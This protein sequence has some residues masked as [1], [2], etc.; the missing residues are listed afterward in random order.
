M[1]INGSSRSNGKFFA[2]HLLRADHNERVEVVEIR[3][4]MAET[5]PAAFREMEAVAS[6]TNCKNYFY[7]ANLNT[8]ADEQLTREQWAEAVDILEKELGLTGQPRFV[9]EHTKE[10]RT[11]QHVVWSRI[12]TDNW[13]AISDSLTYQKHEQAARQ[14]EQRFGHQE[15]P[16]VLVKD[17]DKERPQRRPKDWET[18]RAQES[19]LDPKVITAEITALW[20]AADSASAFAAALAERG[21]ILARGDRRDFCIIDPAGNDHS[22]ARRVSGVKAAGIRER[23]ADLD[24]DALPSVEEGRALARQ[25]HDSTGDTRK[26]DPRP[27]DPFERALQR[28]VREARAQRAS[29]PKPR[30]AQQEPGTARPDRMA[31]FESALLGAVIRASLHQAQAKPD[32]AFRLFMAFWDNMHEYIAGLGEWVHDQFDHLFPQDDP[33]QKNTRPA[34]EPDR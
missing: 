25:R 1:I 9:V 24:R 19:K 34:K 21:Y 27:K 29:K 7:H 17:R 5:V 32:A 3:G 12:N 20:H 10:G 23:M 8:R 11:H 14:I 33:A 6:G 30:R 18:F 4:L 26:R 15:V 31:S 28:Q 16:S 22:L 2:S 13:K